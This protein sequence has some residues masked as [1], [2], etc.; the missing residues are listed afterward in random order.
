MR[1]GDERRG[2]GIGEEGEGREGEGRENRYIHER[3]ERKAEQIKS[4]SEQGCN[5]NSHCT[6]SPYI[7]PHTLLVL[8][9]LI[10]LY[11]GLLRFLA[12]RSL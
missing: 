3:S 11:S 5:V 2:E 7:M 10:F 9:A 8:C 12:T 4:E 6:P 1:R